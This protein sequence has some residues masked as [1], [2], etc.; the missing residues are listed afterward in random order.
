MNAV[1]K[2]A[3]GI[4]GAVGLATAVALL[5][6]AAVLDARLSSVSP[7]QHGLPA[8]GH[9]VLR[10]GPG[11]RPDTVIVD[12]LGPGGGSVTIDGT[13]LFADIIMPGSGDHSG[14]RV[15]AIYN[16]LGRLVERVYNFT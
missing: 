9:A 3:L 15:T 11:A 16:V 5:R 10:Y 13:Q 8:R 7:A 14:L 4:A 2:L 12:L 1:Q 6:P